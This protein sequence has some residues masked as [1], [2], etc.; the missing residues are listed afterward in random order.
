MCPLYTALL[1]RFCIL[2]WHKSSL[3]LRSS[4]FQHSAGDCWMVFSAWGRNYSVFSF[5]VVSR[6]WFIFTTEWTH[7]LR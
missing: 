7:L 1:R 6:I 3:Q 2:V 4:R 5:A